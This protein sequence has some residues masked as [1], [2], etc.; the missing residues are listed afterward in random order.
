VV[1]TTANFISRFTTA[2]SQNK[3]CVFLIHGVDD[4]GGY[5]PLSSTIL[6]ESLQYLDANRETFWEET[7]LNVVKYIKERNDVSVSEISNTG[8]VITV[9]VT[10]TLDDAIY[11]YPV[12]I[13]RPVPG[14]WGSADVSQNGSPVTSSIVLTGSVAYVMFDAVP[15][16]GNVVISKGTYGDVVPNGIV[17]V[18]DLDFFFEFWL[19]EDCNTIDWLDLDEDCAFDFYEFSALADNWK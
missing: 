9:S 5:S 10:D 17:D 1:R 15:D 19:E 12:T 16:G 11:S 2:A 7:F 3:W 8:D 14:G 6:N 4:D 18:N 13:R